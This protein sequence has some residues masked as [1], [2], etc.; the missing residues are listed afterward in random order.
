MNVGPKPPVRDKVTFHLKRAT[1][2]WTIVSL[3]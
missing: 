2:S 3:Q 1:D